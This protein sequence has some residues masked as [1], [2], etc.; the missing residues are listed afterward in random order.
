MT[1]SVNN[2][3]FDRAPRAGQCLRTFLR[4]LGWFGVK[5]GCDAGDCGACTVYVDG[6]PVHSCIF[7]A[8]RAKGHEVTTI[9]GLAAHAAA[10]DGTLHPMQTAFLDAQGF[11]CGF[12]TAGMVMTAASLNQAQRADLPAALKG[13]LCRCTGYRAIEDA[14]AGAVHAEALPNGPALGRNLPAPAGPAVVAGAARYTFDVAPEGALDGLLYMKLARSPHAHARILAIDAGA[15]L[16]VPGVHRVLTHA[17]APQ[18]LYSSGQHEVASSDPSDTMLLDRTVRCIGQRIAAVVADSEG[19]AEEGIRRLVVTYEVL[20][21]V[22]DPEQAMAPGAPVIHDK[23]G[24]AC[25]IADPTRNLV[26]E[27]HGDIGDVEAG[28]AAADLIYEDTFHSQRIQHTPLETHGAVGWID[29]DGRLVIRSSTQVP[30]LT[31]RALCKLFDLPDDKVRVFCA[32]VGGGFGGKQEMLT[33]DVVA[34]AVL[35][36]GRPVKLEFTRE[37]QF[38]ATTTRHPMRVRIKAG[39]TADGKLTALQLNVLSNTGAYG[40]HGPGVLHHACNESIGIYRCPN[41]KVDGHVVYTNTLPAGAF[42]G[43]GLPQTGFAIETAMDELA[44]GLGI[45]PFTFRKTNMIQRGDAVIAVEPEP[46]DMFVGSYGLPRCL[47]MVAAAMRDDVGLAPPPGD[48]WVVGQGMA[49]SMCETI[50]P[51]GHHSDTRALLHADGTYEFIVGTAE[52]GN[53]TTTV[54]TQIAATVLGAQASGIRIKQSDTANG[55]HDTGAYG[56]AGTVV[57]GQATFQAAERLRDAIL[58]AAAAATGTPLAECRLASDHVVCGPRRIGLDTLAALQPETV[59]AA[60]G[61][62]DGMKRSA[63]FNVQSFRIAVNRDTGAIKILQS[64]H[65]A[66]GGRII[67]PMQ[68][69]GQVEGGIAQA[70]GAALY[71]EVAIDATGRVTTANFR[72]YHIPAFADVPRTKVMFAET[73]DANGPF[74]AKSMS[75]APFNP[76][77][78]AL[79]NALRDATGVR[80]TALPLAADRIFDRLR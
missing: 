37:E 71:E 74:G 43:Y 70:L 2:T 4:E 26:G 46:K 27:V 10:P 1:F 9:E 23:D 60:A 25:G 14:L 50:P 20:P 53:G 77:A 62:A 51:G 76:V 16:Q 8:F 31:R 5:K 24:A 13:N 61:K 19:A 22:V 39:A 3:L 75:E 73:D 56:S 55:G 45:D 64:V 7:P 52:F 78:A 58:A 34:L 49:M 44:R 72:S 66:D 42:R 29:A 28:F 35:A 54:H 47:D 79:A 21:A 63:S 11:Q 18:M 68:C 30:F 40:N 36:T 17:D 48:A 15:A 65:A 41:K 67:N 38:I 6:T 69:R 57:A 59:L 33:E 12:C 80:F 32:R